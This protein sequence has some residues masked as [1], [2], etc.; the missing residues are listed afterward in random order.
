M[1]R[2]TEHPPGHCRD[3]LER[4]S[5]Y[6]EG[7]LDP[8]RGAQLERHL[9]ECPDCIRTSEEFKE[10]L[11]MCRKYGA[12][13]EVPDPSPDLTSRIMNSVNSLKEE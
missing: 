4:F 5:Q 2:K 11:D 8:D 3:I 1:T 12:C 7:D 13:K 9:K 10:L 6:L